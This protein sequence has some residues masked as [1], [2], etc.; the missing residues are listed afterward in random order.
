MKKWVIIIGLVLFLA[1]LGFSCIVNRPAA[2]SAAPPHS[3]QYVVLAGKEVYLAET[4]TR[5]GSVYLVTNYYTY[6]KGKWVHAEKP[7]IVTGNV[8]VQALK[9]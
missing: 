8:T 2:S 7:V 3:S 9:R 1:W 4:V 5:Q 6:Q